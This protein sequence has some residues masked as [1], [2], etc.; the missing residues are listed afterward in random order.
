MF[1]PHCANFAQPRV[2]FPR[3]PLSNEG[4]DQP[5]QEQAESSEEEDV[6]EESSEEEEVEKISPYVALLQSLR[7]K[8]K[9]ED[10]FE[11]RAKRRKLGGDSMV[12][13]ETGEGGVIADE[14]EEAVEDE[15]EEEEN[16]EEIEG[17]E[18]DGEDATDPFESHF[19]NPPKNFARA[20]EAVKQNDWTTTQSVQPAG[21]LGRLS[22]SVPTTGDTTA[23]AHAEYIGKKVLKSISDLKLKPRL[24][25]PKCELSH[26]IQLAL[27]PAMFSYTDIYFS[28][29]THLNAPHLRHLYALHILN[30][31]YKTRDRVLK[32]NAKLVKHSFL[33]EDQSKS[34]SSSDPPELRDQ[35]YSRPKVLILLPTRNAALEVIHSIINL[36]QPEQQENRKRF[37]EQFSLPP[38]TEDPLLVSN[39]PDDFK[40]LFG[41]NHDDLFR[42]GIKFTRRTIKFFSSFY[43]SDIIV[44]SPLGLRMAIGASDEESA[45]ADDRNERKKNK[46]H[47][48]QTQDY[49][50]LSSIEIC[51]IDHADALKQQ[52]WEHLEFCMRHLN[53]IPRSLHDTDFSRVR[54]WYLDDCAKFFR[55]TLLLSSYQSPDFNH[56]LNT[57]QRN[58]LSGRLVSRT[59]SFTGFPLTHLSSNLAATAGG[60]TQIWHR[61]HSPLP[62]TDPDSR[63]DF[64][65]KSILH[66]YILSPRAPS[67]GILIFIPTYFDFIRL[68]NHLAHPPPASLPTTSATPTTATFGCISEDTPVPA[69]ARARSH[70]A[71]GRYRLLLYSGRAHHFRRYII[72]GVTEVW[73]YGIPEEPSAYL[74]VGGFLA[75]DPSTLPSTMHNDAARRGSPKVGSVFSRW[76]ALALERVVGSHRVG[77]MLEES[78]GDVFEFL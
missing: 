76:E 43:K 54:E 5:T 7:V 45:F 16:D 21:D 6:T 18:D 62:A 37:Q 66:P 57:Y 48:K 22:I 1:L 34:Q 30:H 12:V 32:N 14:E 42:I 20:I 39:K 73:F 27:A 40:A 61:F 10:S 78:R 75:L 72:K 50:F 26:P 63:F 58:A 24:N 13:E 70:F 56:F 46:K 8:Q 44:A 71:S 64:F 68:R 51:I 31:I 55:Q 35:G 23:T 15:K 4:L 11:R 60:V 74:E 38:G 3:L 19:A 65:T 2:N 77:T 9:S 59:S 33:P 49:D 28:T 69:V 17:D 52:N 29:R 67:Q 36:A 41:G 53:L 25:R 47:Q